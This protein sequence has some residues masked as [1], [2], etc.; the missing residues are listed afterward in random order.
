EM[1]G[2]LHDGR[3]TMEVV[4]GP[5]SSPAPVIPAE[6]DRWNQAQAL[7]DQLYRSILGVAPQGD[8]A[9]RDTEHIYEMGLAGVRDVALALA[10]DAGTRFNGLSQNDAVGVL[11]NLYRG[12]LRRTGNDNDFWNQDPGFRTNVDT[13]RRQGF[14]KMVEVI[15]DAGEF[16]TA[17]D[18]MGFG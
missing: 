1:K 18:L 2:G 12:L 6:R 13:L 11:G 4:G 15:V 9:Q 10:Q 14:S 17:N 7:T 16:R 8:I 5:E 3:I